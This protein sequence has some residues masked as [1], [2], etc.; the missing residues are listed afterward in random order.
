MVSFRRALAA[1]L[2]RIQARFFLALVA[3]VAIAH[4]GQTADAFAE[5]RDRIRRFLVEDNV[6]SVAVAVS[7]GDRVIWEEGFGWANRE[8]R[9]AATAHTPYTIGSTSKPITATALMILHERKLLDV[10]R[11]ANNFLGDAQLRARVGEVARAT[12]RRIM[13][14]TGGLPTYYATF[15]PDEADQL[16]PLDLVLCHYGFLMLTPGERFHYSNLGYAV[17]GRAVER[18]SGQHFGDFLRQEMFVPLGMVNSSAP[19]VADP[20]R[21]RRYWEDGRR[22]PDYTTP[23]PPASDLYASAHDLMRFGQFHLGISL[24]DQRH[25]LAEATV[26]EM[27]QATVPMGDDE[28]GLGWHIRSDAKGRRHV[29]HGGAGAGVDAQLDLLPAEKLS[30]AVLANVTRRTPEASVAEEISAR[31]MA[32]ILGGQP[33]DYWRKTIGRP[34]APA[35]PSGL[36]GVLRG[37]WRGVVHTYEQDLPV[38]L[39]FLPGGDVHARLGSQLTMLVNDA[40]FE[41]GLFRGK[42]P[43]DI[44]TG[45]ANR[46]PYDLVWEVV[47]RGELLCGMLHARARHP[48]RGG[49]F[50]YWVELRRPHAGNGSTGKGMNLDA[51]RNDCHCP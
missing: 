23:H 18:A 6:P 36:P 43:G 3:T 9:V 42:M 27:Q 10:N 39:N 24:A 20:N 29:L 11:P 41:H 22:L 32:K 51:P 12:L 19:P 4:S 37:E 44:G 25:I 48:S 17:L 21:A 47:L 46:R 50:P 49:S 34:G 31:I 7:Q 40:A 30:V 15:Y 13:Q 8:D 5:V 14:H 2:R 45:D 1:I 35:H 33:Q 28:Y 26:R 38:T 16:P